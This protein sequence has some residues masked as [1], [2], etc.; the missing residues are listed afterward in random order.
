[1]IPVDFDPFADAG[2]AGRFPLTEPQREVFAASQ[3]SAEASC[4]Y[5]QCFE[6]RL[7]GPLSVASMARALSQVVERH[8]A[9]RMQV[10]G[11]GE[12]QEVLPA[13]EVTLPVTDVSAMT[14]EERDEVL[15]RL[16][17][18]E[19]RTAFVLTQGPLWRA[20]IVREAAD[21]HR[22]V[23]TAHHLICDGWSSAVVFGDLASAYAADRFGMPAALPPAA[24]YRAFVESAETTSAVAEAKAAEDYWAAQYADGVP[25]FALPIDRP[26]PRLKTYRGGREVMRIDEALYSAVRTLGARQRCTMFVTLLGAFQALMMRL[27]GSV[28]LVVGVPMA[29]QALLDNGHVVAHGVN[30]IP[31]R[32]RALPD[33]S[34]AEHL[35]GARAAFLDAQAHQH[36]TFGSLVHRLQVPRDPA[37]TPLVNVLFNIDRMGAPFVF[38]ELAVEG[39]D[40][41]KA[42]VNFECS[43][44]AVDSGKDLLIEWDYNADL[45]D[46]STVRRWLALY[47]AALERA[48]G[49]PSLPLA[50]ICAPTAEERDL[51][52]SF[53]RTDAPWPRD[54]RIEALV[55]RQGQATPDRVAV[56]AGGKSLTYR[57]LDMRAN[58]VA[59]LLRDAG[60]TAGTLVGLACG[61][62]AHLAVGLLGI[63]KA[64]AGYVPLDPEFPP[65]RLAFMASDATLTHVVTDRSVSGLELSARR[66]DVDDVSPLADPPPAL[67]A[68]D[69]VAYVIYTSGSTGRPKGVLVPHRSV[70]NLLESVRRQP[71][72]SA[73]HTVLAV[74][75]LSFDIAVSEILLPLTV[76]ARIVLAN[77]DEATEGVRLR[78][79]VESEGV[80]FIDATPSTWR[81]LL[82]AGW[83][84]HSGVTAICTGEPL[85]P[86]LGRELLPRVGALW[87]GYG[88]TETTVWSSFH[89]VVT[90]A[91]P[92]P[93]GRPIANTTFHVVDRQLR[94]L[95]IG[96]IG[97]LC[98]GGAGVTL[99]YL[100]RPDLTAERFVPDPSSD[101]PGT[102]WYRTGDLGRW[103]ADGVLEC[104][105]RI[106]HQVK[107]RGYRIEL[108]EIEA[109]LLSH[110]QVGQVVVTVREDS[111]GDERLVAY[112][113][114]NGAMP[115]ASALREHLRTRLPQYMLPQHVVRL[116]AI[117]LLPNGKIDRRALPAPG[118]DEPRRES[119]AP[120]QATPA[121]TAIA[122]IWEELLGVGGVQS[123]DNFFEL[124]GHS[125][126]AM[127]AAAKMEQ[128]LG[129]RIDP[130]RLTVESLGQLA[131]GIAPVDRQTDSRG[132]AACRFG[133]PSREMVGVLQQAPGTAVPRARFLLC[134]PLGQ[135]AVRTAS[136][137][138][139]LSERLAR[140]GCQVLRF[141]YHGTGDSPGDEDA[142]SLEQWVADTVAAHA[143][144]VSAGSGPVYWFG[145]GLGATIALHAALAVPEAPARIIAWEPVLHGPSYVTALLQAHRDELAREFS[146]PWDQLLADGKATEPVVPGDV[147]GF[148]VGP[149]LAG[150]LQRIDTSCLEA[151][152]TR[153]IPT[154]C[155]VFD[156]ERPRLSG[157]ASHEALVIQGV[158]TRTNWMLSQAMGTAIVPAELTRTLLSTLA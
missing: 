146:Q 102:R 158:E 45:F 150:D 124:G 121:E 62:N 155:A 43:V 1:M 130:R 47:R 61:R 76:G 134:R 108:G 14:A 27:S 78:T 151:V 96:A 131:A 41:P 152:I 12:A 2:D 129:V 144:L 132:L 23:F 31:L 8:A 84:G 112:V 126:L 120:R 154:T 137:F 140:E 157:L 44:N 143:Q 93:I 15:A 22:L 99:G 91:G 9:L 51:L 119:A 69:D 97:E 135:E 30:A 5:N 73:D 79:L 145:M 6:L 50:E 107:V 117:P 109:N 149:R 85:P 136:V 80:D 114:A 25:E 35:Q 38:G 115:A 133:S 106:D 19:V 88:P 128:Q 3:V 42:F 29:S 113:V 24:P 63:L 103:R 13:V 156:D 58:A 64:G 89:H 10:V 141:D 36:V 52:A 28:D 21:L 100:G 111:P 127:R 32:C 18:R 33:Q 153:G 11:D 95:P 37:R 125:L 34:F 72:M 66:L 48:A 94:P 87:N 4:A 70:T 147:L 49:D 40:A 54:A 20:Q 98:I 90:I 86:D 26:R 82:A 138:R 65:D 104:L 17:D 92:V 74:T 105:G 75:T 81:M 59:A 67:G 60:V 53:N 39:I 46:A 123:G 101:V 56:T 71:G 116:A 110:P 122:A 118:D 16:L 148:D 55:A 77:R 68:P 57:E 139:V 7:R 83:Q 142:Q